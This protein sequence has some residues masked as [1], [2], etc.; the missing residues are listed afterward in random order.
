MLAP[1]PRLPAEALRATSSTTLCCLRAGAGACPA[2]GLATVGDDA[3]FVHGLDS[4]VAIG[5]LT[6]GRTSSHRLLPLV[7]QSAAIQAAYAST[8]HCTVALPG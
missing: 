7:K 1:L 3:R 8:L 5:A 6:K 2:L 4:Y